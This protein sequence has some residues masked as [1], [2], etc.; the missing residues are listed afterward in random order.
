MGKELL[1]L[2][3][4]RIVGSPGAFTVEGLADQY[5]QAVEEVENRPIEKDI[6]NPKE[7]VETLEKYLRVGES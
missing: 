4:L 3:F 1:R 7:K 2:K 6:A 5:M